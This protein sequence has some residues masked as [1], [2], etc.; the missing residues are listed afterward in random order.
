M[1][2]AKPT[3]A[4]PQA[5]PPR[6]VDVVFGI[7]DR[8]S[9]GGVVA[10]VGCALALHALAWSWTISSDLS[11]ESWS[12]AVAARVHAE[13]GREANIDLPKPERPPEPPPPTPDPAT[14][15][16]RIDPRAYAAPPAPAEAGAI[17][18]QD[19]DPSAPVDLSNTFV[20]GTA[21]TYAGGATSFSGTSPHAVTGSTAATGTPSA[22]GPAPAAKLPAVDRARPVGVLDPSWSCPWPREADAESIDEQVA[23]VRVTVRQDGTVET[24]SI[25]SDPG[26]GFGRAA[27]ACAR[28][29]RFAAAR[30]REGHPMRAESGP[31]RVR[32]TR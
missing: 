16:A 26:F 20:T 12:A 30:N 9:R 14:P 17:V 2:T 4:S 29:S 10:G 13:L 24:A 32:F 3:P 21:E 22:L 19:A 31:I 28:A 5:A 1:T 15:M 25:V 8:V 23:V 11:L 27:L 7:G 6:I 18:A